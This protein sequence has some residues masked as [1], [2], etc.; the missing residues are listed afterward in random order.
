MPASWPNCCALDNLNPVYH[1]ENGIRTLKEL[2][3]SYLT[4]TRD[5]TRV[6]N[7]LKAMYRSWAIPCAGQ[8]VYAPRHRA[9]WL[10]QD[11]G[12]RRAP[13]SGTLLPAVRCAAALRQQVRR[14]L[15]AESRKHRP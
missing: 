5:L 4:I 8:Q 15:L 10:A 6:M 3:R 11:H 9:E 13:P 12:S 7:R 1:G 14:E 2:A